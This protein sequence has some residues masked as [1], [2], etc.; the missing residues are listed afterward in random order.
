MRRLLL[1]SLLIASVVACTRQQAT[2]DSVTPLAPPDTL[3]EPTTTRPAPTTTLDVE[4]TS[5]SRVDPV[6]LQPLD[7]AAPLTMG[8]WS[9][10]YWADTSDNGRWLAM[11]V[12]NENSGLSELRLVDLQA[13][14]VVEAWS[15][16]YGGA[17]HVDDEGTVRTVGGSPEL[18]SY[19]PSP[20]GARA[21]IDLPS[22]FST[23]FPIAVQQDRVFMLGAVTTGMTSEASIV[24]VDLSSGEMRDIALP[25]VPIG[26]V[27]QIPVRPSQVADVDVTP[28]VVWDWP[29][30]LLV[31]AGEDVVSEVDL[32]TGA[33]SQHRFG[34]GEL[35]VGELGELD[36][37]VI[38]VAYLGHQRTAVLAPDGRTLFVGTQSAEL[39]TG[40]TSWQATSFPT[41]LTTID[42]A[43][44]EVIDHVEAPISNITI[45]PDGSR[46]L[47]TG[48]INTQAGNSYSYESSNYY[49]IDPTN[50]EVLTEYRLENP[51]TNSFSPASFGPGGIA[52]ITS[53]GDPMTTIQVIDLDDGA[54]LNTLTGQELW[55]LGPVGVLG[56][57]G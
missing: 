23:W 46:L 56:Q 11:T 12:G 42:T 45:S 33:V 1:V 28:S 51:M 14:E 43:N 20:G 47:G 19:S 3:S 34:P 5:I 35:E 52:Y 53:W 50:R 32:E 30:A 39:T 49:V 31:H 4:Q 8:D 40:E 44:W 21:A 38:G 15:T 2:E 37:S 6:T 26:L 54:V 10:W 57:V 24:V 36:E 27:D 48:Y 18:L 55:M 41:G 7:G 9:D 16:S 17:L 25:E 29:R 22:G 13:W